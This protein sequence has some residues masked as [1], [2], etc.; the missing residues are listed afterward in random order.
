MG[1]AAS[2]E[3]AAQDAMARALVA[4]PNFRGQRGLRPWLHRIAA[5]RCIDLIRSRQSRLLR[6]TE[7][8][9]LEELPASPTLMPVDKMEAEQERQ[10]QITVIREVLKD[11]KEPDRT[12]LE[13]HYTHGVGY[14]EIA[15]QAELSRAAVKQR[16]W[17]A[18]KRVRSLLEKKGER[19]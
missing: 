16:I 12:W 7:A 3:D 9:P 4:L 5:N 8:I 19:T 14:D 6:T 10:H 13:L 15:E 2:G 1:C 17:R 18:V 11:I